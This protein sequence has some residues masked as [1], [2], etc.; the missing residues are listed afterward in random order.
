MIKN[1]K[2]RNWK[3]NQVQVAYKS[4]DQVKANRQNK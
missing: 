3:T 4:K 2:P 1:R